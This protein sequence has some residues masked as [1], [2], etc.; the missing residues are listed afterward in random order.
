MTKA[1]LAAI[2]ADKAEITKKVADA[3]I[4]AFM[5]AVSGALAKGESVSLVG[6]GTFKVGAR[7]ERAGRNPRTGEPVTIPA[8]KTAK[9][10]P[11]KKLKGLLNP[12]PPPEPPKAAGKA[13]KKK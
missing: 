5:E 10:A 11:G 7:A 8:A 13:K 6:F 3:A 2:L 1:D 9:F 12:A 4:G